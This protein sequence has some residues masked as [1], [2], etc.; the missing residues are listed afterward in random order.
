MRAVIYTRI[1]LDRTGEGEGTDRQEEAC[2]QLCAMRGWLVVD[3]ISDISVSAYKDVER[4]GWE[5]VLEMMRKGEV[6]VVVAWKMDRVTRTVSGLIDIIKVTTQTSCA[7]AT[8][9]GMLDLTTPTGKAVATILAAVAQMEVEL[10]VERQKLANQQRREKGEP[11]KSGWK[12]FGYTYEGEI[13]PEQGDLIRRGALDFLMGKSLGEIATEWDASGQKPR[14]GGKW[15][16]TS[17]REILRNPRMAGWMTFQ[18]ENLGIKGLWE[19]ILDEETH[20]LIVSRLASPDRRQGGSKAGP[21][22]ENLLTGLAVCGKCGE[23]VFGRGKDGKGNPAYRCEGSHITTSRPDADGLVVGAFAMAVQTMLPGLVLSIP[24]PGTDTA[25]LGALTAEH[26]KLEELA[27]G[28]ANG[29]VSLTFARRAESS[30]RARIADLEAKVDQQGGTDYDP[31]KLNRQTVKDFLQ[32]DMEGQRAVLS[33]LARIELHPAG[34]G[35]K[36]VPTRHQVTMSVKLTRKDGSIE[37]LPV[38]DE[39][40]VE[41]KKPLTLVR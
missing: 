31:R 26:E 5:R 20:L 8:T 23:K 21:K 14:S 39:L 24:S 37:W 2:R 25:L 40:P 29:S 16:R 11:W 27:D 1:S 12:T 9:D 32:R 22:A 33:R 38:L 7:F 35:K 18:K 19:P 41:R 13:I 28:F 34:R 30:I 17:V 6:D 15:N 10:K 4:P 3:A 36:N